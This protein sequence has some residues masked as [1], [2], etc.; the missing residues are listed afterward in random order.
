MKA[1]QVTDS[2]EDISMLDIDDEREREKVPSSLS[3]M[4]SMFGGNAK[5]KC[6]L[7]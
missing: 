4:W 3:A 5:N 6:G 1:R 7:H 2:E